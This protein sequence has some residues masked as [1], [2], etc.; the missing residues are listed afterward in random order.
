MFASGSSGLARSNMHLST[1]AEHLLKAASD[2]LTKGPAAGCLWLVLVWLS[3]LLV[4]KRLVKFVCLLTGIDDRDLIKSIIARI[5]TPTQLLLI[6]LA[7]T[8]LLSLIPGPIG[9]LLGGSAGFFAPFLALHILI[10]ASDIAVSQW[11]VRT[12]SAGVPSAFRFSALA[13][14]YLVGVLLLLDW[15]LGVN[16]LP[17]LATSTVIT[18]VLG[19]SLQDTL[20]NIFAGLTMTLEKSIKQGDWVTF[21]IDP[22]NTCLGQVLEIGWRSTKIK[23]AN[24][25]VAIIPNILLIQNELINYNAPSP[26]NGKVVDFPVRSKAGPGI[27]CAAIVEAAKSAE[28]VLADPAPE[29]CAREFKIDQIV[30]QLRFWMDSFEKQE[31]ITSQVIDAAW[32]R[33]SLLAVGGGEADKE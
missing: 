10:Q 31:E 21:R 30:Y 3:L 5:D 23:T 4:R 15:T 7:V 24:N 16:V 9:T 12:R 1:I 6:L 19:L 17:I 20:R 2:V 25:N 28:G 18:A 29:A 33:L 14:V 8:P 13:L 11:Y 32:K 27:V 22:N 26:T